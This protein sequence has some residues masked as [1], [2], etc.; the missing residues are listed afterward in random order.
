[1]PP[2]VQDF[3]SLDPYSP[4]KPLE[5]LAEE[6]GVKVGD[7]VK[8]DANENLFGPLPAVQDAIAKCDLYHIYPDPG[9]AALRKAIA[10]FLAS[11]GVG[12]E[13]VCGGCG[14]DEL[15][16]LIIRLFH[17]KA[18]INMPPTF[19]MYPFLAKIARTD[20]LTVNRGPAPDFAI[21]YDA[22]EAAVA[23]TGG[24]AVIF[25]ASPNNPTG[26]MLTHAEVE[27][28]CS[29][30]AVVV[31]DEAYAEF[32]PPP[33]SAVGLVPRFGN[34][35][36]LRTFSKWAGLAGLRV[37]YS[38]AHATT[39]AA[40]MGIKQPYN[41]NV[42]ADYAARAAL[43][44]AGE[45]M[46]TQV[47]PLRLQRDR[48]FAA[49][50][51]SAWLAPCPTDANFVLSEVRPP[52]VASEVYA[53]LRRRGV[54]TRYYPSGRL[55]NYI[56]ISTGRPIDIDR[57]LLALGEV[58]AEQAAAYGAVLLPKR[59]NAVL[60]DMDGVLVSVG[61][62]YREAIIAT[63]RAF[64]AEVT[65]ADI[66]AVKAAGDAN[67]D[68]VVSQRLIAAKSATAGAA[69]RDA[70][71]AA[72]TEAF[73]RFYQGDAAA[74]LPG[75]KLREEP[76]LSAATLRAIKA[77]CPGG[78]AVV[79]GRPR[80]DAAEAIAR[81]GWAGIFDAVVCMED[82][83]KPKPDPAPVALAIARLQALH[84]A[85]LA[86][87]PSSGAGAGASAGS[88]S[89]GSGGGLSPADAAAAAASL[90]NAGT[91]VM[92]GD[93]VDDARAAVAAGVAALGVFPPE[94]APGTPKGD[95]LQAGLLAAGATA[96]LLP[97][98][99]KLLPA[100]PEREDEAKLFTDNRARVAAYAASGSCSSNSSASSSSAAPAAA[101]HGGAGAGA[102][103]PKPAAAAGARVGACERK[104]KE[105]SIAARVNLDGTGESDV[106]TGIGFLDHMLSAFAKHGHFDVTLTCTGDLHI[107]DHHTAE[108]CALAL[109]EA[110]DAALGARKGIRRW[111]SALCPLDEALARAVIDIS[112]RPW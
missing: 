27:R 111:G 37:G 8:L 104:T 59:A 33:A 84:A 41:V 32:S 38:V 51:A 1:M 43:E 76:L 28:L 46:A 13:H 4:V 45:I 26:R 95:A 94:K 25:A 10:G 36:V 52:F 67:N 106:R 78:F 40:L 71:L 93:T 57:L 11:P 96:V 31:V 48:L 72:V 88:S 5:V 66:D 65:H 79:T 105:T 29:L 101:A 35:V 50:E 85:R 60:W 108:D 44:H 19:G 107:D 23:A 77:R 47:T 61:A 24:S 86:A 69:G 102:A 97:G 39:T 74:G 98:C 21:D 90:V 9:Q 20:V 73:E 12:P 68:W 18:I 54:L 30:R 58:A 89:S 15:L 112:S 14:S 109:G 34:L 2:C 81:F 64:G 53:A 87:G 7:L 80:A 3:D 75:L 92:I 55:R 42:A 70:S 110:F 103:A 99:P 63:A 22:V 16:D 82:T 100:L 62:S 91:A 83:P 17:P 49:L 56:R 6:I